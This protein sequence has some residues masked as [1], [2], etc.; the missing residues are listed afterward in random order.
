MLCWNSLKVC[1]KEKSILTKTKKTFEEGIVIWKKLFWLSNQGNLFIHL[2]ILS[3][4]VES[5]WSGGYG[6]ISVWGTPSSG[7]PGQQARDKAGRRGKGVG[8]PSSLEHSIQQEEFE[9]A[10]EKG[11]CYHLCILMTILDFFIFLDTIK[12]I[13]LHHS[14]LFLLQTVSGAMGSCNYAI[15]MIYHLYWAATLHRCFHYF[16]VGSI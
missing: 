3:E 9:H 4:E 5:Q 16:W 6:A 7:S 10:L 13:S 1:E 15:Y 8:G 12:L 11:L 14:L 2:F